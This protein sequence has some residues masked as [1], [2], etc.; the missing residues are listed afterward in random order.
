MT[1]KLVPELLDA[2]LSPLEPLC[3][4]PSRDR[5]PTVQSGAGQQHLQAFAL[6]PRDGFDM[7][8]DGVPEGARA[9]WAS[10]ASLRA[11]R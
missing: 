2:S 4:F 10:T 11:S 3:R 6:L 7:L 9:A 1:Q 8:F 5:V